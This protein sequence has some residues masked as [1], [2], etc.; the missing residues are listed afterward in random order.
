MIVAG[1]LHFY[2]SRR[3]D[4]SSSLLK[5][6]SPEDRGARDLAQSQLPAQFHGSSPT[7]NLSVGRG[8]EFTPSSSNVNHSTASFFAKVMEC[9]HRIASIPSFLIGSILQTYDKLAHGVVFIFNT[10]SRLGSS[11]T[12]LYCS[13]STW[14]SN[15][16]S[17]LFLSCRTG[18]SGT[19][20][21]IIAHAKKTSIFITYYWC[22]LRNVVADC[23]RLM[24]GNSSD[25][26]DGASHVF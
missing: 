23:F 7:S 25:S 1:V 3:G 14:V 21:T 18:F 5:L 6:H 22:H 24:R 19:H 15:T 10:P 26:S 8:S 20:Q 2:M 13:V 4:E 12:A 11:M 16:L 9:A 17:F